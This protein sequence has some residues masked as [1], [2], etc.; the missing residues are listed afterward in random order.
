MSKIICCNGYEYDIPSDDIVQKHITEPK[1]SAEIIINQINNERLYDKYLKGKK[2]LTVL[3]IGANVG[4]FTVYAHDCAKQVISVEPTPSHHEVFE[5]LT[6]K[7][8]NVKLVKAALAAQDG[9]VNFYISNVNSTVNS[10]ENKT[11]TS[12]TVQGVCFETLLKDVDK[13]DFCKIDIEGSEVQAVTL[14]TLAPVFDKIDSIYIEVHATAP[15]N[16]HYVNGIKMMEI[17]SRAGYTLELKKFNLDFFDT[18]YAYK[19]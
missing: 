13:V 12:V 3:D 15:H 6:G 14:E 7:L 8:T 5:V 16:L 17:L 11:D 10:L 1:N 9:E 18:I 4:F 19:D 2:D